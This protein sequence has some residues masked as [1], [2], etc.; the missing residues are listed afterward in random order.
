MR[1]QAGASPAQVPPVTRAMPL[2]GP[3]GPGVSEQRSPGA[4]YGQV[5]L[6][7]GSRVSDLCLCRS[8]ASKGGALL[9]RPSTSSYTGAGQGL[10]TKSQEAT[11]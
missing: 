11:P 3:R 9:P 7:W 8:T 5:S 6:C 4:G 2:A 10:H 1:A